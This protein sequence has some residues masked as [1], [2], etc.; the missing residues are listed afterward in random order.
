MKKVINNLS[1]IAFLSVCSIPTYAQETNWFEADHLSFYSV[2]N[3]IPNSDIL[4]YSQKNGGQL[5]KQVTVG[6]DGNFLLQGDKYFTPAFVLNS[7]QKNAKGINGTGMVSFYDAKEFSFNNLSLKSSD[8][9]HMLSWIGEAN[10]YEP[11]SFKIMKSIDGI[12]YESI[13]KVNAVSTSGA[14]PY[15]YQDNGV[16]GAFYKIVVV[17]D[18]KGER[19][20]SKVVVLESKTVKVFPSPTNSSIN[21]VTDNV[22]QDA[23]YCIVNEFGQLMLNGKLAGNRQNVDIKHFPAGN[24]IIIVGTDKKNFSARIVKL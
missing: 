23:E 20:T 4:F 9:V 18:N 6:I 22:R 24:Y 3:C 14:V 5:L 10:P 15:T 2:K 13:G 1:L 21:I 11:I 19:Y 17:N 8:G 16:D 12:N 7:K